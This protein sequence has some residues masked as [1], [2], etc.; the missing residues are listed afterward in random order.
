[1]NF[2]K[3]AKIYRYTKENIKEAS[4]ILNSGGLVS[5]PTGIFYNL[6]TKLETVY[7]LGANALNKDAVEKIFKVKNRPANGK[8]NILIIL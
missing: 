8:R 7:G 4:R 1:M 6:L 2:M 5:F 3:K